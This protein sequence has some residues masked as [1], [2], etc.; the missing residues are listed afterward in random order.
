MINNKIGIT[1]MG[2]S[3]VSYKKNLPL[4]S[5]LDLVSKK[6]KVRLKEKIIL[7]SLFINTII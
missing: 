1:F 2:D 7:I 4:T 5:W 3:I 6:L